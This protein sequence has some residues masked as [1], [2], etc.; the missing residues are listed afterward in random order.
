ML[1][2]PG[3]WTYVHVTPSGREQRYSTKKAYEKAIGKKVVMPRKQPIK[4]L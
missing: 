4:F 2:K 3:K 1:G